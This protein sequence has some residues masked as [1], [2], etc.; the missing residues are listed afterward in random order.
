MEMKMMRTKEIPTMAKL[1]WG[2]DQEDIYKI[3]DFLEGLKKE[4]EERLKEL[5]KPKRKRFRVGICP[6]DCEKEISYLFVTTKE[7]RVNTFIA[8]LAADDA[9]DDV[10]TRIITRSWLDPTD[11]SITYID[12]GNWS[13][14]AVVKEIYD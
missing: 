4:K 7:K 10:A 1:D 13:Y 8:N 9:E 14:Y 11:S 3:I 5:E 12:F 6:V 2:L